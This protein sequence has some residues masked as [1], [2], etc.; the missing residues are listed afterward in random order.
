MFIEK[1]SELNIEQ[2]EIIN[3][4]LT[5]IYNKDKTIEKIT[6]CNNYLDMNY[7]QKLQEPRFREWIKMYL[8]QI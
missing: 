5:C 6:G 7:I 2:Y 3:T 8:F 4:L 1:L